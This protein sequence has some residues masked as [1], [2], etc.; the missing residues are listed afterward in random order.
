[1]VNLTGWQATLWAGWSVICIG[2]FLYCSYTDLRTRLILNRVTYPFLLATLLLAVLVGQ[3]VAA[4]LGALVGG[5]VLLGPRLIGGRQ[6]A[7][8]GD[9]KLGALGGML[10]GPEPAFYALTLAFTV[11]ILVLTPLLLTRRL[12]LRQTIAFGPFLAV[13]FITLIGLSLL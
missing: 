2:A 7:G 12:R 3:P 10:L 8:M 1:M 4:L 5:G 13:G 9:V 11:A 6:R